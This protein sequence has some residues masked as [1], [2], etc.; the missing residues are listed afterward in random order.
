MF[1]V[2][3]SATTRDYEISSDGQ[4]ILLLKRVGQT[5]SRSFT[6]ALNWKHLTAGR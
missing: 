2:D 1:A 3:E 6:L 4:R 5:A